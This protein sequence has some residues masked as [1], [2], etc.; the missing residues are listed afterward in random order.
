VKIFNW[1]ATMWG[2]S[3]RFTTPMLFAIAAVATFTMGGVSG[4]MHATSPHDL[5]Q[6]DTYFVVAHFHYVLLGGLVLGVFAG[7]YYWYPKVTG[8]MMSEKLG[9]WSF[10]IYT[11]GLHLT[12]LPMHWI[13]LLGMP[14]RVFTYS[15]ELGLGT[16]NALASAGGFL[17]AIGVLLIYINVV[18]SLKRGEVAS[19]NP[20]GAATLEW[21]TESPPLEHNFNRTPTVHSR[22]PL[23]LEREQVE[24]AVFGRKES[25]HM[26]P[27]SYWPILTAAGVVG[28][29][30][31][32]MTGLW[33]TPLIGLTWTAVCVVNW[34]YE[35]T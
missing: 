30:I 14:R 9:R 29:F 12:F 28:T 18:R 2:G 7:L 34:A 11:I 16:L 26:P 13:G 22:E 20:W 31:L 4:V 17:S 25:F 6:T 35:P 33:W 19:R 8:R 15:S 5:Q 27:G 21:A 10:W 23:W 24:T 1:I 3:I 32:F